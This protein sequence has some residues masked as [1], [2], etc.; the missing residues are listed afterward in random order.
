[1]GFGAETLFMLGLG[2]VLLGPKQ[3]Q[4]LLQRA[5]R[6]KAEWDKA[7]SGLKAQLVA[8][9]EDDLP[10]RLDTSKNAGPEE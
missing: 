10:H 8:E 1:M 2:L 3:V 9:L 7:S 5:A 6:A 4:S